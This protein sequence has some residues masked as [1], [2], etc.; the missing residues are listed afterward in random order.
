M[1]TYSSDHPSAQDTQSGPA[2]GQSAQTSVDSV[3]AQQGEF[4]GMGHHGDVHQGGFSGD[5]EPAVQ[6]GN[7]RNTAAAPE[8][9]G[10][11]RSSGHHG[12]VGDSS[13][14]SSG[15]T[16][17]THYIDD[18]HAGTGTHVPRSGLNQGTQPYSDNSDVTSH[19]QHKSYHW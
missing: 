10:F 19:G 6:Q 4:A 17:G 2:T 18:T 13:Y 11:G 9:G 5:V 12:G 14:G 1:N 16:V 8:T 7:Y 15:T 3:R